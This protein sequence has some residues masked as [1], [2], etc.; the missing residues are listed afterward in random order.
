MK[1]LNVGISL[2]LLAASAVIAPAAMVTYTFTGLVPTNNGPMPGSF[3]LTVP[4]F[5]TGTPMSEFM[6]SDFTSC[7]A[8]GT[9]A[10]IAE[11]MVQPGPISGLSDN[12]GFGNDVCCFIY[13]F[14]DGS[15]TN[16]G[17]YTAD[18]FHS[19][20]NA[21]LVVTASTVP[22]PSTLGLT[23]ALAVVFLIV[24]LMIFRRR[25]LNELPRS[26]DQRLRV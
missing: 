13:Y 10:C 15:F 16:P 26:D 25:W 8:P 22:E 4:N 24:A 6:G 18:P 23:S 1:I 20:Q 21:T 14:P 17:T 3:V 19:A 2:S 7:T 9:G 12:I 5:I 11:F